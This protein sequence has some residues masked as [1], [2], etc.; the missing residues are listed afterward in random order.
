MI[1]S[2]DDPKYVIITPARNEQDFIVHTVESI[3]SQT[4]RPLRWIIV[5]DGSTDNTEAI[6]QEYVRKHD[7]IELVNLNRN[8]NRNF[9]KKAMAFR[10][11]MAEIQDLDYE[12]IGNLDADISLEQNYYRSIINKFYE[13]HKL[14]VAGGIVYTKIGNRFSTSD[15][16]LDSVGGAVQL[17]RKLCFVEIGGY[18]PLAW[19][20]ID[21]AAEIKARMLGWKVRKFAE[22]KVLEYRR[23]G[24]AGMSLI[25]N[26]IREGRRFY[27]LG[28][29][30]SF[31]LLRCI[32]RVKDRPFIIGSVLSCYGF[33]ESIIRRRPILLPT[34]LVLFLREEQRQR[35]ANLI[36]R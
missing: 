20:G 27:S 1:N 7:F 19:G 8:G 6:V 17:F 34:D 24:S 13:D 23:T 25:E 10:R 33:L 35:L 26:K 15:E 5:N 32:Y 3:I 11:G 29:D 22:H 31:Y 36:K 12:F 28:Y 30:A 4:L 14:G 21:A 18:I 16:T 2:K 9:G